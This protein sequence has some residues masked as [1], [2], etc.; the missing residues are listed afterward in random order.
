MADSDSWSQLKRFMQI[1]AK[2]QAKP[3]FFST[4]VFIYLLFV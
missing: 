4:Y 3:T 2:A 1:K